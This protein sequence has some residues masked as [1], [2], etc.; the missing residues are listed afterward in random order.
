[1][2]KTPEE[3]REANC[4]KAR[5]YRATEKGAKVS[6]AAVDRYR[7]SS[8]GRQTARRAAVKNRRT[9][10]GF[11]RILR[12]RSERRGTSFDLSVSDV[13]ELLA[14][15]MCA[16]TGMPLRWKEGLAIGQRADALSPSIDR[17]DNKGGYT[18]GNV[19]CVAL[20]VN[21]ARNDMPLDEFKAVLAAFKEMPNG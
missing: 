12:L 5:K 3:L 19:Q 17:I 14:P 11:C 20:W 15:M 1:M 16:V 6:R 4:E 9:P 18:R 21:L 8:A 7:V 10:V 2:A 13:E